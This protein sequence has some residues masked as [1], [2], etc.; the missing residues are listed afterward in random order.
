[1]ADDE[2]STSS[3]DEDVSNPPSTP[4]TTKESSRKKGRREESTED[5]CGTVLSDEVA[6]NKYVI[7]IP[8]ELKYVLINDWDLVVHQK[9]LFKVPAKVTVSNIIEQYIVHLAS[10]ES[11]SAKRSVAT[12][13]IKGLGEYFNVSVGPQLL[14]AVEKLQ[15]KE[16]FLIQGNKME[17]Y[18]LR[19]MR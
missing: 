3:R 4:V 6:E 15:Y 11:C 2:I 9:Q 5:V 16:V 1:L 7:D 13:V 10:Q 14:Y 12:E 19:I 8:E 17:N 18:I